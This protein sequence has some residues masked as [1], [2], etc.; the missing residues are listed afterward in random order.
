MLVFLCDILLFPERAFLSRIY[1]FFGP[2]QV[3][4]SFLEY[5]CMAS[6]ISLFAEL[7][8]EGLIKSANSYVVHQHVFAK[9][10]DKR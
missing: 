2:N 4:G 5:I 8:R 1:T 7:L 9:C 6:I 10:D 3:R